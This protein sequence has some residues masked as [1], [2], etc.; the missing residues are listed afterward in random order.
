MIPAETTT[1]EKRPRKGRRPTHLGTCQICGK[2]YVVTESVTPPVIRPHGYDTLKGRSMMRVPCGGSGQQPLEFDSTHTALTLRFL[3]AQ[4]ADLIER[5]GAMEAG[6]GPPPGLS[7]LDALKVRF[8]DDE[9]LAAEQLARDR[10]LA[11]TSI[12]LCNR[13]IDR[14]TRMLVTREQA[15][16]LPTLSDLARSEDYRAH[17]GD[18]FRGSSDGRLYTIE[19]IVPAPAIAKHGSRKPV[20]APHYL[21]RRN[22]DGTVHRFLQASITRALKSQGGSLPATGRPPE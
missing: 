1:I 10:S 17:V 21:C 8:A 19:S 4:L 18:V 13:D 12:D 9:R 5:R 20:R 11:K 2:L 15:P 14:L 3:K 22:H 16:T 6:T 7:G